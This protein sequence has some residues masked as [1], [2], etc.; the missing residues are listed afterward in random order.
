VGVCKRCADDAFWLYGKLP[1]AWLSVSRSYPC[2]H[3]HTYCKLAENAQAF[4]VGITQWRTKFRR[5][6]IA[7]EN[8]ASNKVRRARLVCSC[9]CALAGLLTLGLFLPAAAPMW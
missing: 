7:N 3:S 1:L 9:L 8:D 6:M 4:T 2:N 5:D